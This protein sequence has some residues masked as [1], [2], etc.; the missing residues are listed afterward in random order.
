[1]KKSDYKYQIGEEPLEG[2]KLIGPYLF[3][4]GDNGAFNKFKDTFRI[5]IV[6]KKPPFDSVY[7]VGE[8]KLFDKR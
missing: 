5:D 2:E 3:G 7:K 6:A 8:I 1:M 4:S